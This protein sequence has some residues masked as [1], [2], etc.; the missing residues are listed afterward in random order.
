MMRM[1]T[2]AVLVAVL[3]GCLTCLAQNGEPV[4][5]AANLSEGRELGVGIQLDFPFG[6]LIS[7]RYWFETEFGLEGI[8]MLW[9]YDGDIEGT[10]TGRTL[11]RIADASVVDFYGVVGA[12]L[13]FSSYDYGFGPIIVSAAGGI[14]FGFRSA[15]SLAW[16]IEFGV[17]ISGDGDLQMV[18]GTGIHFYFVA[19]EDGDAG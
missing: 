5:D 18:F 2:V 3:V 7:A 16:N 15:P 8:L 12:T 1:R 4:S 14:E 9:G 13:P 11:Y 6:G 19:P 10:F 17:S